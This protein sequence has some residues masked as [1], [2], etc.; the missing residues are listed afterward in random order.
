MCD[1]IHG[2][3]VF[4][5]RFEQ[6]SLGLWGGAVDLIR[7]NDLSHDRPGAELKFSFLLVE[8]GYACHVAGQHIRRKLDAVEG[9]VQ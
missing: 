9:A 3:L 8:N 1:P 5:H 2:H 6:G 7:Q 4:F